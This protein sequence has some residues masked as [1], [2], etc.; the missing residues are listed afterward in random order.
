[1]AGGFFEKGGGGNNNPDSAQC[2]QDREHRAAGPRTHRARKKRIAKWGEHE[3]AG[4]GERVVFR[5]R[6]RGG[7]KYFSIKKIGVG[8]WKGKNLA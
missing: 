8:P 3:S 6:A 2:S 7:R 5:R 4:G 1:L